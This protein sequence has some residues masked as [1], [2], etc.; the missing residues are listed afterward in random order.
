MSATVATDDELVDVEA[1][2]PR[3]RCVAT[4]ERRS[5]ERMLRFVVGPEE[6]LV[7]DADET[8]PGR[9]LWLSADG[10]VVKKAVAGRAFAKAARRRVVVDEA[11]PRQIDEQLATRC[12]QWLGLA[13]RAGLVTIGF[14]QVEVAAREGALALFVIASDAGHDGSAKLMRYDLPTSKLFHSVDV[15]RALGRTSAVY[16]GLRPGRLVSRLVRD[17]DRLGAL[18]GH[19]VTSTDV[20]FG[21]D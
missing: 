12:L 14:D 4:R 18:R 7:F 3:R 15:G 11:L 10:E 6:R 20:T 1:E 16:V 9:G 21:D 13:R 17:V 5:R 19:A 8:L 2:G